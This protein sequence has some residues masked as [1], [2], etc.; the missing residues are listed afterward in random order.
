MSISTASQAWTPADP[1]FEEVVREAFDG[2]P[3]MALLGA[4]LVAVEPGHVEIRMPCAE[5]VMS[6]IPGI[7]H[8]GTVGMIA[9]SSMGFAALS[10][11]P[12]GQIGVT[13]EYKINMLSAAS[14]D[15]LTAH[16]HVVKPGSRVTVA[17]ADVIAFG[18]GGEKLVATALGTLMAL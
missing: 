9:D 1:R 3:A 8:G 12:P 16:G 18:A 5:T 15:Y 2:Q 14:G 7:V 17:R 4:T 6:H 11:A 10:L 13:I